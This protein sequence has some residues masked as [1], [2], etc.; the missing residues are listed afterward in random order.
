[1]SAHE[2]TA[3]TDS[4]DR[5]FPPVGWLSSFALACVIIGGI[6]MASY[7]PR[8][9]PLVATTLLLVVGVLLLLGALTMLAR[10]K[11]FAWATFRTVFKWALL[12]Y[13]IIAGMIEFAFVRDSTRGASLVLVTCMLVVFMLSVPTTM[14]FTTARFAEPD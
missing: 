1:M 5:P 12:A 7:A 9:A 11:D 3:P 14:A 4:G 8:K 6:L 2:S 13:A 10:L